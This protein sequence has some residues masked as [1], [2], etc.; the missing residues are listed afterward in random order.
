MDNSIINAASQWDLDIRAIRKDIAICGSPERCEFRFVVECANN[1]LYV[2]ESLAENEVNHKH[3]II[4]RLNYLFARGLNGITPCLSAKDGR[5]IVKSDERFWQLSRFIDGIAVKRPGYVFD[6]WRGN[7][8]AHFLIDLRRASLKM[9]GLESKTPFSITGF[10]HT[11]VNQI[12]NYEPELHKN[13]LPV[14]DFLEKNFM[15]TYDRLP[16][17]FCHGDYH[18]LNIIWSETGINAVIDWE[19]CGIKPEIYDIANM[20]GCIGI[21]NPEALAGPLVTDFISGL[22]DAAIISDL[23]WTVLLEFCVALRF[24]WLSEW[25]RHNDREMIEMETVYMDLLVRNADDLKGI[26]KV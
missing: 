16:A 25:L 9:P 22:K 6:Q 8:L 12:K 21:E 4:D 13:L 2:I 19:F 20:I 11:L 10:I 17:A 15:K 24:A 23:S 26:W 5:Y 7:V 3:M 1:D 14:I 18:A